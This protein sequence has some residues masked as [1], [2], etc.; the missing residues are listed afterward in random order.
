MPLSA[1]PRAHTHTPSGGLLQRTQRGLRVPGGAPLRNSQ[2]AAPAPPPLSSRAPPSAQHHFIGQQFA[3]FYEARAA[4]FELRGGFAQAQAVFESGLARRAQ[5]LERL[6][7]K[8][9]AFKVRCDAR[10]AAK[11]ERAQ[12]GLPEEEEE[13][14]AAFGR[15]AFAPRAFAPPPPVNGVSFRPQ[16]PPPQHAP[17]G[18]ADVEVF[19]DD[20]ENGAPPPAVA[21]APW[22]TLGSQVERSKE[23][24]LIA[25]T[26]TAA[27]HPAPA[28]AARGGPAPLP[29]SELDIYED[30]CCLPAGVAREFAQS[31]AALGVTAQPPP[32]AAAAPKPAPAAPPPV[33]VAAP[34][35]AHVP[36]RPALVSVPAHPSTLLS[37]ADGEE[38]VEERRARA[39]MDAFALSSS[40][41]VVEM[42]GDCE[43]EEE[44]AEEGETLPELR[45]DGMG[46][47]GIP[48]CMTVNLRE[49]YAD[50][51]GMFGGGG[52]F[53]G[54][55]EEEAPAEAAPAAAAGGGGGGFGDFDVR[56]DTIAF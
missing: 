47:G 1:P 42:E 20:D 31:F 40:V 7:V 13:A 29:P 45:M 21:K 27:L 38:C 25:S 39:W 30:T 10:A 26:W 37:N 17:A 12:L 51:M 49:A 34:P 35:H 43:V 48:A 24:S 4:F 44:V 3:L 11:L 55:E 36:P 15:G 23:N 50:I 53:G 54:F 9:A 18:G 56:E 52:G 5:P 22:T 19:C 41:V 14:G 16:P 2:T 32:A 6:Q 33:P 28:A 8:F 46:G